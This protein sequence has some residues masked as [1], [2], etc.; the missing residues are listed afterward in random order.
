[1]ATQIP[2]GHALAGKVYSVGLFK[3]VQSRPGFMNLLSGNL[4][5]QRQ[6]EAKAKGQTS[7][8][9]PIVKATDLAHMAGDSVSV[10]LFNM[11]KGKPVMGDT[12]TA[13]KAM[14]LTS[15]SMD[16]IINQ[17]RGLADGAGRMAQQRTKHNLRGIAMS[18]L[19]N[20]MGRLEDQ[21]CLVH[22]AGQRGTQNTTDWVVPLDTDTDF[23][24]IMVNSV[25]TPTFNRHYYANNASTPANID[26][27]DYLTWMD[28]ERVA[29][30]IKEST[31]PLQSVVFKDDPYSWNDPLWVMFVSERQWLYLKA[32]AYYRDALKNAY[33]RRSGG[34]KHPLFYGDCGFWSGVIVKPLNRYAI[35]FPTG[36]SVNYYS[37]ASTATSAN[38]A[39]DVD[40]AIIVGAQALIKAY[41]RSSNSDYHYDW[42]EELI[43]HKN[44]V[45]ICAGMVGGVAKPRFTVDDVL[46]DHGVAVLDSYA[47]DPASTAGATL[48]ATAKTF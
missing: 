30:S 19:V 13:G 42:D 5:Q 23:T 33:E 29:A 48:L 45:E 43:D 38:T 39:V 47:P 46:T 17:Y 34:S 9:M 40:R 44:A 7:A 35:R 8:D 2:Y 22:L 15:S 12:R 10:D 18:E 14:S 37:D 26:T 36:T 3:Q 41:G 1:M 6:A 31:V 21:L 25:Q 24:S 20:Y 16:V 4:P 11:L 28:I 27:A 32:Q